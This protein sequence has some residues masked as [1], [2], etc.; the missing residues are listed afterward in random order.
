MKKDR[1]QKIIRL[2]LSAS[3]ILFITGCLSGCNETSLQDPF[4]D[5]ES[6]FIGSWLDEDDTI[7]VFKEDGSGRIDESIDVSWRVDE[8]KFYLSYYKEENYITLTYYYTFSEDYNT[9]DLEHVSE[10]DF[11]AQLRRM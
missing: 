6:K 11:S 10:P 3:V 7:Q 5:I 9:L 1:K 8:D 4:V 2:G